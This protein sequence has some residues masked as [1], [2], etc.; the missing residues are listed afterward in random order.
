MLSPLNSYVEVLTPKY[1][2]MGPYLEKEL[3]QVS[4]ELQYDY[5]GSGR[6]SVNGVLIERMSWEETEAPTEVR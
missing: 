6:V 1:L 4:F 3:L 5:T 2:R